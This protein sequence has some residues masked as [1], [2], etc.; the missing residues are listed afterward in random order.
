MN[1]TN[2]INSRRKWV[3]GIDRGGTFTDVVAIS[4]EGRI[5]TC[6]FLSEDP[7]RYQDAAI[8]AIHQ[9]LHVPASRDI[10]SKAVHSLRLGTTVATNTLLERKGVSVCLVSTKGFGDALEI[11]N[12]ARP[13]LFKLDIHKPVK[14]YEE[15][16]EI[17]ERIDSRGNILI[18]PEPE[19]M[20]RKLKTTYERGFRSLAIVY[21]NSYK[22]DRHEQLTADAARRIGFS[23]ISL[24]SETRRLQKLTERGN[25]TLVDAYLNPAL[26]KYVQ[27]VRSH[28][29]RVPLKFMKTSGGLV[30]AEHFSAKEAIIS[31]PAGGVIGYSYIARSLGIEKVIGFDMGG[32]STDVSR[33]EDGRYEMVYE[34]EISGVRISSPAINIVTVAAGGGSILHFDGFKLTVGPDSA[35]ASPGPACYRNGGP[36]TVTDANLFLGRILPEHFPMVFGPTHDQTLDPELV[37]GK[38]KEL[39]DL[40]FKATRIRKT[41]EEVASGCITIANGNMVKSIKEISVAKGFNIQEYTLFCFGGAGAQHACAIARSLGI[42]RILI[43]SMA[44][45]LSAFGLILADIIHEEARSVLLPFELDNIPG[46]MDDM[47]RIEEKLVT[48]VQSEGFSKGQIYVKR[49]LDVRPKGTDTAETIPFKDYETCRKDFQEQYK[50]QYGFLPRKELEIVNIRVKVW[51][52]LPK[53]EE[54]IFPLDPRRLLSSEAEEYTRVYLGGSWHP[55]TPVF[56]RKQ[57]DPGNRISGPAIIID[58]NSTVVVEPGFEAAINEGGHILLEQIQTQAKVNKIPTSC[59]PILLEIFNNQFVSIAEQMGRSLQRTAH[60]VNIKERLD[61]S[62]ALFDQQAGL[63]ANAPHIPVHLGAMGESVAHILKNCRMSPGDVFV[64]NDPFSGGS[65]LPDITVVT[66]FFDEHSRLIFFVAS[67]G[68]HADIGGSTPG[69]MPPFSKTLSEEGLLIRNVKLVS[70]GKFNHEEI[71]RCLSSGLF[72]ARNLQERLSDLRAQVAANHHGVRE[73]HRMIDTHGIEVVRAYMQHVQSNAEKVMRRAISKIPDGAYQAADYLDDGTKLQVSMEIHEDQAIIDFNGTSAQVSGNLNAPPAITRAAILYVFRTLIEESIPL[74]AGCFKPLTVIIPEGSVLNPKPGA[75][76]AGG[77][78][79]TSQRIVDVLY[80]SLNYVAASQGTMNNLTFGDRD[81]GYYETI[82][83]GAGAGPGF[84]GADAVHTHMTNTRLTDPEVL[85]YRYPEIRLKEF[86][87]RQESGGLGHYRG[88]KGIVRKIEFL[89]PCTVSILSE[90]RLYPPYGI[91]GAL[92][93]KCGKNYILS[94]DGMLKSCGGKESLEVD[95]GDVFCIETPGGGGYNLDSRQ[96]KIWKPT[97]MRRL[98]R[99]GRWN[100]P[101]TGLCDGYAQMNLL[102][103]PEEYATSFTQFCRLNPKPCPLL[104]VLRAGDPVSLQLAP[105]ADIRTDVPRYWIYEKGRFK[106]E[107]QDIRDLWRDDLCVFLMGCSFTFEA[108]LLRA[109]LPVRH[110]ELKR[111]VPMYITGK[112]C[113]S[114]GPF[115]GK[116]VVTMRPM[117]KRQARK[118]YAIA[119]RYPSSHGAPLCRQPGNP[120]TLVTDPTELGIKDLNSPD[121]GSSVPIYSNEV[122]VFWAC[123]VTSQTAAIEAGLDLFISHAPGYMFISDLKNSSLS[124]LSGI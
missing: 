8:Y 65:H 37:R 58:P 64:T 110:V 59:D 69:S 94:S 60:S 121:F 104:E 61:F 83:G 40:I 92:P 102:V 36:L 82:G 35:G 49:Y 72:P 109:G 111:N 51:G 105:G 112:N 106:R 31:G 67:R 42:K 9:L 3:I 115:S 95:R 70:N 78:V 85:E 10:S 48:K 46:I 113:K 7:G 57:L 118:A 120:E 123:G 75:A 101:T 98:I 100:Q 63:V 45:V 87:I 97:E 84:D 93:G 96:L 122:P 55:D 80:R 103:L 11:G 5:V 6:K 119:A 73:L 27:Q 4:P 53:P 124:E 108:A 30:D 47:A 13:E 79:E 116:M 86:S 21:L 32:T 20:E 28:T 68:H 117:T 39:S 52:E 88:G 33:Y 71:S 91:N 29:G 54:P 90:R 56:L 14:L 99:H 1:V 76:V 25:T 77:N 23:Q 89:K 24:S 34:M 26:Y 50:R 41:P 43:H 62:C 18:P 12:Q 44:G 107:V 16:V 81:F 2:N 15:V 66:P 22:N 38:F 74:N 17:E 114:S 19:E